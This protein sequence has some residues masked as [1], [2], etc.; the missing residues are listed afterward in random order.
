MRRLISEWNVTQ[1]VSD[2]SE[3]TVHLMAS[4]WDE[5]ADHQRE[6]PGEEDPPGQPR[7]SN[8]TEQDPSSKTEGNASYTHKLRLVDLRASWTTTNRNIAFG[9]YDSYKKVAVLKRNLSTEALKGLRIDTQLQAKKLR[10]APSNYSPTMAPASPVL[11]TPARVEKNQNEVYNSHKDWSRES[12]QNAMTLR[13]TETAGRV[14]LSA[15][16]A[17]LLQYE[18]HPAVT[19]DTLKQKNH[20][21]LPCLTACSTSHHGTQP[22]EQAGPQAVA[23]VYLFIQA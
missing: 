8:R 12:N 3:V 17:Q 11:P 16:K 1:M 21:D 10:R 5:T 13:G 23:G 6:R 9:L 2:L 14:L 22:S 18:H 20:L 4:T 19:N 7:Q 15:A